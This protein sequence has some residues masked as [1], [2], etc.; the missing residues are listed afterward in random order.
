MQSYYADL[1]IHIGRTN[2]G[3]AV[4]ITASKELTFYNIMEE[5]T[6]RKGMDIV[7][8][9]DCQSPAVQEDIEHYL[10]QG[11]MNEVDGGG[12]RF[13]N[14]TMILGSE[15]EINDEGFGPAHV[16]VYLPELKSMKDFTTW[17]SKHM[18]N[19]NLSTQRLYVPA[20]ILQ[21]EVIQRGGLFIPAHI[22]T[23]HKSIY[24]SSKRLSYYL[25]KE[26]ISAVELGLSADTE[27]AGYLSELS[28]YTFL[29]NSDA[30]S[31]SKIAREYNKLWLKEPN[32]IELKKALL[33]IDG[34]KV[35][36]NY[37]LNP[38]L[39][40]YNRTYCSNCESIIDEN[41]SVVGRCTYCGSEKIVRG[42]FDR[43]KQLADQEKS[44]IENKPPYYYQIPLE[45]IPGLGPRKL[46]QLLTRFGTEMNVLHHTTKEQ[47]CE[48]VGDQLAEQIMLSR[49][50]R[51]IIQTGG[52]GKYGKI[53]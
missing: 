50:G 12:I 48:V 25:Y 18:K 33:R 40:K 42:V 22:F 1:H 23:P 43:I 20:R 19:V 32:F 17:M 30:H 9:I 39:G 2:K 47:I 10:N 13:G 7:G 16:L 11:I 45:F 27:M 46:N 26:H 8:I 44:H 28:E 35:I 5:A 24:G 6:S 52:G 14:T 31:L 21:E 34:R 36:A 53:K 49:E 3:Q 29:T 15:I 41:T 37:G 51:S 4:K 38:K